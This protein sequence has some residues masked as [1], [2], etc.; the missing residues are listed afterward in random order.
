MSGVVVPGGAFE[1]FHH[2][3]LTHELIPHGH[4]STSVSRSRIRSV[5]TWTG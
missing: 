5:M 2:V 3:V 1:L 4:E